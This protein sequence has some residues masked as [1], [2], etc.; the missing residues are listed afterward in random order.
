MSK[1]TIKYFSKKVFEKY[2]SKNNFRKTNIEKYFFGKI[3]V[4]NLGFLM[5]F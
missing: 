3:S 4:E 2:F 5:H 1:K